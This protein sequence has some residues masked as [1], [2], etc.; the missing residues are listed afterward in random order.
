MEGDQMARD[1][2]PDK[3]AAI[4][5]KPQAR[6]DRRGESISLAKT[7]KPYRQ[8]ASHPWKRMKK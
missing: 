6:K 1:A 2:L 3:T 5:A 8:P 4:S 7:V